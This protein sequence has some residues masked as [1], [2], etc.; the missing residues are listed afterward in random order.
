[1]LARYLARHGLADGPAFTLATR[2]GVRQVVLEDDSQISVCLGPVA[3]QGPGRAV[4][5]GQPCPGLRV[6]VGNPHL[7]CLVD[8]PPAAFDFTRPPQLDGGEFPGGA[9]VELAQV[10]AP[11]TLAMRVYERGSGET[12]SCGT[13]A[14]AAAAAAAHAE[15]ADREAWRVSVPGG[16]LGVR[17]AGGV[18]WLTGPAV[19]VAEGELDPGWLAAAATGD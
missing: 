13:G 7:A 5:G 3:V 17:L 19:I 10:T 1:V 2:A 14:V 18:G 15:G 12:R 4:V 11:G 9:N 8:R 6:S 16:V